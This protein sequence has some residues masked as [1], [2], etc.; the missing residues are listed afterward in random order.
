MPAKK[1]RPY[2]HRKYGVEDSSG[3]ILI[4]PHLTSLSEIFKAAAELADSRGES[5]YL[6][7]VKKPSGPRLNRQEVSSLRP[8][9]TSKTPPK[10]TDA[11]LRREIVEA[12]ATHWTEPL[13]SSRQKTDTELKR[14]ILTTMTAPWIDKG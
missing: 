8:A 13:S 6:F 3:N 4:S 10:K 14:E 7:E 12:M 9:R 1:K 5:V 11:E 2:G